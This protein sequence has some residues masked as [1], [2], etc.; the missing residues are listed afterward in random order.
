M[1]HP[2]HCEILASFLLLV[3]SVVPSDT[4][5]ISYSCKWYSLQHFSIW[6]SRISHVCHTSLLALPHVKYFSDTLQLTFSWNLRFLG[7]KL[8][9]I[10]EF[11]CWSSIFHHYPWLWSCDFH[12]V[13]FPEWSLSI[14]YL[15]ILS[16]VFLMLRWICYSFNFVWIVESVLLLSVLSVC[17]STGHVGDKMTSVVI[18]GC[19]GHHPHVYLWF[20]QLSVA[21]ANLLHYLANLVPHTKTLPTFLF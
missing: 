7:V 12:S 15:R 19:Y 13:L 6:Q 18:N 8:M 2:I 20:Q 3:V 14:I 1:V 5:Y 21:L 11:G 17:E 10:H 16:H 9:N 4:H